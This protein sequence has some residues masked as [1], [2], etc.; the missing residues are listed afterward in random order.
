MGVVTYMNKLINSN[1]FAYNRLQLSS[2]VSSDI[3]HAS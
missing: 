3:L 1:G 2:S